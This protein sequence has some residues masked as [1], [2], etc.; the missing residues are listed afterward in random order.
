MRESAVLLQ[1]DGLHLSIRTG[2]TAEPM[3]HGVELDIRRGQVHGLVGESGAGKTL[4]A[5]TVLGILPPA[6]RAIAT[7]VLSADT[8]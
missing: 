5:K 3:L 4:V 1:V 8:S 6:A 7:Y 2:R